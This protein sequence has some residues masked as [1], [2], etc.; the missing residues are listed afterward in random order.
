VNISGATGTS[1]SVVAADVGNIRAT[2]S[3]T[4]YDPGLSVS[5]PVLGTLGDAATASTDVTINGASNKVGT[6]WTLTPPTWS[7]TGISTSYQWLRD[8]TAIPGATSTTYKLTDADIGMSV[9]VR[10]TGSK[11]GH[12]PG[13]S[14]SNAVVAEQLDTLTSSSAP[15]ITGVAAARETLSATP[16]GWPS[17]STYAYQWFVNGLAVAKETRSTYVVRT[18]DAGLPVSVRVTASK[19]GFLPGTGTSADVRVAKLAT[20][21]T[22][23]L[24]AKKISKRSRAVMLVDVTVLDLG[25]P[26]GQIQVKKGTKVLATV[27]IKVG[28]NGELSIRLKKLPPGKHKLSV[29]YTGSTSTEASKAKPVKLIVLRT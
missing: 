14:T 25:V 15:T 6:T 10:A 16:G 28:S 4:G 29:F 20:S 9:T 27:G 26:L 19:T 21:L 22:A 7:T 24:K 3:R 2:G 17:G 13:T 12:Q 23:T 18:R 1:Y 5:D 8:A 11:T